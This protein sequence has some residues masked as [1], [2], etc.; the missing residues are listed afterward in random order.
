MKKVIY[1]AV[2]LTEESAEDLK[3]WA[4]ALVGE[5]LPKTFCH[6]MTIAFRP[7]DG[8]GDLVVGQEVELKV[9]AVA[10]NDRGQ[11]VEVVG[12]DS[13]NDVPH[14]TISCAEGVSPVYSNELLAARVAVEGPTLRGVVG[15]FDGKSKQFED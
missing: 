4:A 5:L 9:V 10:H 1:T 15:Y 13:N 12:F 2:F 6:H 14:I 8:L 3:A 11:A 7:K